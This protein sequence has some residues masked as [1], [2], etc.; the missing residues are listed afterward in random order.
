MTRDAL[1][2]TNH[3]AGSVDD[4]TVT[5]ISDILREGFDL[6][7]AHTETPQALTE[8]LATMRG[9]HVI[10]AGGD[11]SLHLLINTLA[12]MG[13]LDTVVVGLIPMGTG[14]DFAGGVGIPDDPVAAAR[15][16]LTASPQPFDVLESD[17][18]EFVVNVAHAGIGA[19]A[20]QRAQP[21]KQ[22]LGPLAY[23][24]GA[25]Q[26][27]ISESGYHVTL[28]LDGE[29]VYQ[30]EMLMTL[31]ANGPCIGGGAQLC[32][33]ADATDGQIDVIVID[34]MPVHERAGLAL[35]IQ[36]ATLGERD[37]VHRWRGRE[38]RITGEP[39]DHNRD[40][41]IRTDLTEVCYTVRP[42][43]WQLLR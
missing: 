18:G 26:A 35:A 20:A 8:A 4:D 43:A 13:R 40:G 33:G 27:G 9:D 14:N 19:V 10:V 32:S 6:Q 41:E 1:L 39:L 42:A 22:T 21:A 30:N 34:T 28:T 23:P 25:L 38:V 2:V 36:R 16:C 7:V 3:A 12:G 31:V 15:A 11:G 24:L 5:Q 17:D 29:Q 37:D